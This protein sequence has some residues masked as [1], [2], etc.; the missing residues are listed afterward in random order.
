MAE[1]LAFLTAAELARRYREGSAT[2]VDAVE[3]A[4]ARLARVEP[5]LN[6]FQRVDAEG[7]RAAAQ[8]SASRWR[9]G[10]PLSPLDGVPVSI[11][12]TLLAKGW[13]TLQGSRTVDV[14]QS[15]REDAPEVARLRE[16]GAILLGK[17]TTPE[18]GWKALTDSPLK[19]VTR[20]PWNPEMTPGGSS[21]GAAASLAAGIGAL[22]LGTDGGGSIRI[23]ASHCGLYGF[24]PSFG[25]VPHYPH[26]S[27]FNTTVSSGPLAR[28]VED[29]ALMLN[30][31][32]KPDPR[33]VTALP[34]DARDWHQGLDD[35]VKGLRIA[36]APGLGGA[37]PH[38][39]V[40]RPV[41]EAVKL[42]G[43]LGAAVAET[44]G[45]IDKLQP[46]FEPYWLASFA[47]TLRQMPRDRHELLDPRF[48]LLAE[49]GLSVGLEAYCAGAMARIH[50]AERLQAFHADY[51]LLV[52]PVLPTAPPPVT[53]PYH[54]AAY[55]RWRDAVPYTLP[56]NLAGNPAASIPCGVT[57]NGLPVG[58]QI[59]GPR[60]ADA[61][62]LRASRALEQ[63]LRWPMP[64]P[65]LSASL[66]RIAG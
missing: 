13:P 21:G 28:S 23:P 29:A 25:R 64:H 65:L 15:W 5:V 44:G 16:A 1:D 52:T 32:A 59:A 18:F 7:A 33:D 22:A 46:V 36:F 8:Q 51:D 17:T 47:H 45:I 66:E 27:P 62:V 56:F 42:L 40:L 35:G 55:D 60:F 30:A 10:A 43:E 41:S 39:E 50:L 57:E 48:R 2:P 24:K 49:Q 12:D 4:L 14:E 63:A 19:G 34:H 54:S 6:A 61:L 37:E 26:K 11:K 58:V 20:S 53:T 38:A 9:E 31:L 3:T